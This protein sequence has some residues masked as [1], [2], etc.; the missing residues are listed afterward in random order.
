MADSQVRIEH[1]ISAF[2]IMGYNDTERMF[3]AV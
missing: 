2:L 1:V 3:H